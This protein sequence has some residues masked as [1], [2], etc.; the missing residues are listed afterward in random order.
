[1]ESANEFHPGAWSRR[2]VLDT[3]S[4]RLQGPAHHNSWGLAPEIRS[5]AV[6]LSALPPPVDSQYR[7]ARHPVLTRGWTN[8]PIFY[9]LMRAVKARTA[10]NSRVHR[11][12]QLGP[13]CMRSRGT[14]RSASSARAR[15]LTVHEPRQ[16]QPTADN[17]FDFRESGCQF[18]GGRLKG[19]TCVNLA[20]S[21]IAAG[22]YQLGLPLGDR[23]GLAPRAPGERIRGQPRDRHSRAPSPE[24]PSPEAP[25]DEPRLTSPEPELP[26]PEAP[27]PSLGPIAL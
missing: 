26:S 22:G 27:V 7:S 13:T 20:T 18:S 14:G 21:R 25:T 3:E 8:T 4:K 11:S 23:G 17:Q 9:W 1:M 2:T 15:D 10:N 24:L 6:R 19:A 12:R 5:S 16:P